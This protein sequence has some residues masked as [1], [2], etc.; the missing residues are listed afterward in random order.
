MITSEQQ[1]QQQQH[2]QQH[3][4]VFLLS[5]G[6]ATDGAAATGEF[7]EDVCLKI[8]QG[9][10]VLRDLK[11]CGIIMVLGDDRGLSQENESVIVK[12]TP[13]THLFRVSLGPDI[14]FACHCVTLLHH[15]LDK[16][17]H[18]CLLRPPR[19]M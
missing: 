9:G 18:N 14:L 6:N 11:T 16:C 13:A 2:S 4:L 5:G 12:T 17:L 19:R 10:N 3:P 15:Y 8:L 1:Q 7:I